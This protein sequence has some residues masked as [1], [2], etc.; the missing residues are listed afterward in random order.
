MELQIKNDFLDI[1]ENP[2]N[3]PEEVIAAGIDSIRSL[4]RQVYDA[5]RRLE[6][7]LID[8]MTEDE[9]TKM[10]FI[11]AQGEAKEITLS[12]GAMNADKA[13]ENAYRQ[14]GFNCEEIG[15]YV[16]KPSW[17]KSKKALK[18]GGNKKKIIETYFQEGPKT[19]KIV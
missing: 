16:F 8:R 4:V 10:C 14:A 12:K 11:D 7:N 3:Y 2:D 18:F 15:D 13:L 1:L 19:L 5:K 6:K 9:A 17:L